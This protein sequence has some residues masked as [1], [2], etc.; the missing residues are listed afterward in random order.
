MGLLLPNTFVEPDSEGCVMMVMENGCEPVVLEVGHV[1]GELLDVKCNEASD[2]EGRQ[3]VVSAV[4]MGDDFGKES[5]QRLKEE[6]KFASLRK[7]LIS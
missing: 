7:K 4:T 3:G 5:V 6:V 1:L 2:G